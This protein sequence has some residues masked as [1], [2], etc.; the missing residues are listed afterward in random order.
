MKRRMI[1]LASGLFVLGLFF[2]YRWYFGRDLR[3]RNNSGTLNEV[4]IKTFGCEVID[5]NPAHPILIAK[6]IEPSLIVEEIR[7][8]TITLH[9]TLKNL[10]PSGIRYSGSPS[11]RIIDDG[12]NKEIYVTLTPR[13]KTELKFSNTSKTQDFMFS[14][15]G[16]S[17][18]N[19]SPFTNSRGSYFI[20]NDLVRNVNASKDL[21][22]VHLGDIVSSGKK[23]HWRRLQSQIAKFKKP[24][25]PVL[26]NED[27]DMSPQG[28]D[29]FRS[30]F[31]NENYSFSYADCAF[32]F[33]DNSRKYHAEEGWDW[34]KAELK[35]YPN[36]RKFVFLHIPPRHPVNREK[37]FEGWS[38]QTEKIFTDILTT[39]HVEAVFASHLHD[40]AH[41]TQ[42]G[43]TYWVTGGAGG[44]PEKTIVAGFHFLRVKVKPNSPLE[45]EVVP[46]S[47]KPSL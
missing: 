31:G 28:R 21:F 26:G 20:W 14:V 47:N 4:E 18:G 27:V 41:F 45:V 17:E 25:F 29:H 9:M 46:L 11:S 30:L 15:S 44:R 6:S 36:L 23:Q 38:P 12:T 37:Y 7:N 43:V 32:V 34:L 1:I 42:D 13:E 39:A 16:C 3:P 33:F 35:K 5:S 19:D 10:L 24:L 2:V 40:Y 8:S 22:T